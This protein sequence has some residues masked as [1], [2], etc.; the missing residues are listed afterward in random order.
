MPRSISTSETTATFCS[1][2]LNVRLPGVER[3][4]AKAL[5]GEAHAGLSILE[6]DTRQH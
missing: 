4:A 3:N 6:S 5:V 2:R 1:M